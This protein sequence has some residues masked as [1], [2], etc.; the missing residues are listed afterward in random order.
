MVALWAVFGLAQCVILF[1]KP[2]MAAR[3][4]DATVVQYSNA[5]LLLLSMLVAAMHIWGSRS[6]DPYVFYRLTMLATLSKLFLCA[7]AVLVYVKMAGS[8]KNKNGVYASVLLYAV[9][10]TVEVAAALQM[11]NRKDEENKRT[12]PA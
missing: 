7:I 8:A 9:Y 3:N 5:G 6:K 10:T 12:S 4:I 1:A 11:S 2:W